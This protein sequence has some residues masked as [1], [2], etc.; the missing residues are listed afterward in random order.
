[1]SE[2]QTCGVS[3]LAAPDRQKPFQSQAGAISTWETAAE[4]SV[5][6][7]YTCPFRNFRACI[8]RQNPWNQE[9]GIFGISA[10]RSIYSSIFSLI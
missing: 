7:F 6:P 10:S 3:Q 4:R 2:L 9:S 8:G 5:F 1:M